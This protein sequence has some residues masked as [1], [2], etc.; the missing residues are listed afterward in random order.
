[1]VSYSMFYMSFLLPVLD[2]RLDNNLWV[3]NFAS[4][5]T[6]IIFQVLSLIAER[7][8]REVSH[9]VYSVSLLYFIFLSEFMYIPYCILS[10]FLFYEKLCNYVRIS[11]LSSCGHEPLALRFEFIPFWLCVFLLYSYFLMSFPYGN[12]IL[13]V[14]Y[15][16]VHTCVYIVWFLLEIIFCISIFAHYSFFRGVPLFFFWFSGRYSHPKHILSSHH[17]YK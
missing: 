2:S 1:M 3:C 17:Q 11:Y 10:P 9:R 16:F 15:S 8:L 14:L 6:L 5:L 4:A 13:V 7:C 12:F